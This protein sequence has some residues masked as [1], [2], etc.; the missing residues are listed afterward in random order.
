MAGTLLLHVGL[1]LFLEGVWDSY[2]SFDAL[3]YAGVWL[4]VVVMTLYGMVRSSILDNLLCRSF[5]DA[6]R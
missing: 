1:D 5:S 6:H 3:E 2:G 4:I